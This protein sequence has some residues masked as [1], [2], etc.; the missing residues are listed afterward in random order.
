[1]RKLR[2]GEGMGLVRA[3]ELNHF[4]GP[5]HLLELIPELALDPAQV[6]R[7]AAIHKRMKEQAV[8]QGENILEAEFHLANIFA[9]GQPRP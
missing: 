9:S 2:N 6:E 1:M 7:I 4:P 3:A 8:A 5:K